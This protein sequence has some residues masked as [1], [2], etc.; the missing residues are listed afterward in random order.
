M[1]QIHV[2]FFTDLF[3]KESYTTLSNPLAC[4]ESLEID[5]RYKNAHVF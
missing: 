1:L 5:F 3:I 2:I 4:R